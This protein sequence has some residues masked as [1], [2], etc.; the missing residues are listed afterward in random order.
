MTNR[1]P[2]FI[3]GADRSGTTLLR[4][5]LNRHSRLC[6][7]PE[8]HFIVDLYHENNGKIFPDRICES[9]STHPRYL[10]WALPH[11]LLCDKLRRGPREWSTIFDIL[12]SEYAIRQGK[13]R[14][15]DKTPVYVEHLRLL[16]Q[17]FPKAK[18]IHIIRDGRDVACSLKEVPWYNEVG[19]SIVGA[20]ERW[21][22][23]VSAGHRDGLMLGKE[24]YLE[25]F[26]EKL[27]LDPEATLR[28]VC[29][30][31]GESYEPDMLLYYETAEDHI[32]RH[33]MD[34]HQRT[35]QPVNKDRVRRW[36]TDLTSIEIGLFEFYAGSLLCK[37]GYEI[38]NKVSMKIIPPLLYQ[39]VSFYFTQFRTW[40]RSLLNHR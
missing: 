14:W 30:H 40:L 20:A 10:E 7:P 18:I 36:E 39:S 6:I 4:L 13:S 3:V 1:A 34:W 23:V 29:Q 16:N 22:R 37:L 32:P 5:M 28:I 11:Q 9:L 25:I 2:F 19:G 24:V 26:Y 31:I 33:R 8:S 21:R 38:N 35:T 27:V 15:G 17:I 12:F